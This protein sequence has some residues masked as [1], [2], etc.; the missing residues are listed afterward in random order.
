[1]RIHCISHGG[2]VTSSLAVQL[3]KLGHTVTGSDD[4]IYEPSKTL[5]AQYG[6]LP[7]TQ[8]WNPDM[9]TSDID[10]IV[11]GMHATADNPELV[12]AKEL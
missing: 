7:D 6:L 2:R 5:L 8:G 10:L 11:L 9:I 1:M 3:Q 12:K 4:E